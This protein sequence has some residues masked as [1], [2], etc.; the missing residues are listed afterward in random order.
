MSK[1]F[2]DLKN[3]RLQ[4]INLMT[5]HRHLLFWVLLFL[6]WLVNVS[7]SNS[8]VTDTFFQVS[9]GNCIVA[10]LTAMILFRFISSFR[11]SNI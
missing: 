11:S 5:N 1:T 4:G 3:W 8:A 7:T 2:S 9:F 6:F 10:S